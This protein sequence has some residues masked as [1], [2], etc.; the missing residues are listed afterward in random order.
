M[1]SS[2]WVAA[3]F[4][5]T[6]VMPVSG[7]AVFRRQAS[8]R[9]G[10]IGP[11]LS[12]ESR[13]QPEPRQPA[14]AQRSFCRL[15]RRRCASGRLFSTTSCGHGAGLLQMPHALPPGSQRHG[16][17]A[18]PGGFRP[19]QRLRHR[20]RQHRSGGHAGGRRGGKSA[21]PGVARQARRRDRVCISSPGSRPRLPISPAATGFNYVRMPGPD[22]KMDQFAH[23]SVIMI[24]TPDGRMSKYLFG[25]D[26]Q[27]RDVRLAVIEASN[28]HIGSVS[29]LILLYC[30]NYSPSAGK[31]TVSDPAGDGPGRNGLSLYAGGAALRPLPQA[32]ENR[33]PRVSSRPGIPQRNQGNRCHPHP[34]P[35]FSGEGQCA[36]GSILTVSYSAEP[37]PAKSRCPCRD[38]TY[39]TLSQEPLSYTHQ[40][41]QDQEAGALPSLLHRSEVVN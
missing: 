35:C 21:L 5:L 16:Q 13:H 18:A 32:K 30:C 22:G 34:R 29:D 33:H 27:P 39:V 1:S 20:R 11:R 14:P 24:A 19:R 31:Y 15:Q 26:Y 8:G 3:A 9:G 38:P 23:S 6:L 2:C 41:L 7:A 36:R 40:S 17:D 4:V 25:I 10:A 12:Q 37:G 28:H